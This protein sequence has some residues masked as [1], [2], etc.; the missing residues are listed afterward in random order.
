MSQLEREKVE[1]KLENVVDILIDS[2]YVV[3]TSGGKVIIYS[4]PV[5]Y[6]S[7]AH[8]VSKLVGEQLTVTATY[9]TKTGIYGIQIENENK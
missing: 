9:S 1:N 6:L 5:N 2:G 3:Q 4:D 8:K 7:E